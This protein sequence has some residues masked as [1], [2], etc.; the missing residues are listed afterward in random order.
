MMTKYDVARLLQWQRLEK[1]GGCAIASLLVWGGMVI[2]DSC[3][4]GGCAI[5]QTVTA[6]GT[7]G[8]TVT[9]TGP[10]TI[11]GGTTQ[12]ANLFHSFTEFSPSTATTEFSV[13]GTIER[14]FS[15]V[16]GS[17]VSNIDGILRVTGGINPDFFLINPNGIVFG[18]NAELDMNGSFIGSTASS[19]VF[20][21]NLEF[22]A[23]DTTVS[24][25][26]TINQPI[27]L[28]LGSNPGSIVTQSLTED[29]EI[30]DQTIG[31][32]GGEITIDQTKIEVDMGR[33]ELLAGANGTV[34]LS[35]DSLVI[36]ETQPILGEWRNITLKGSDAELEANGDGAGTIQVQGATVALTEASEIQADTFGT[37]SG[38]EIRIYAT[39][40]IRLSGPDPTDFGSF[41]LITT[42]VQNGANATGA[43]IILEA[44]NM[45]FNDGAFLEAKLEG[46]GQGGNITLNATGNIVFQGADEDGFSS[47]ISLEVDDTGVGQ[48]GS[49]FL[50]AQQL[51]MRE[52][53]VID[54]D[55]EGNGNGGDINITVDY[56][57]LSGVDPGDDAGSIT[58]QV[59]RRNPFTV[60]GGNINITA[61]DIVLKDGNSIESSTFSDGN[62]GNVSITAQRITVDSATPDEDGRISRIT[63]GSEISSSSSANL[64]PT[65]AGGTINLTVSDLRVINNGQ[66]FAGT[67]TEGNAGDL[68]ITGQTITIENGGLVSVNTTGSGNAG[69]LSINATTL[70][71]NESGQ[72]FA[73][74]EAAGNAGNLN[75]TGQTVTIENDGIVSVSSTGTGNAGNLSVNATNLYLN[76]GGQLQAESSAGSQ[77]NID[78]TASEILLLRRGS[79]ISTNATGSATGGNIKINAPVIAGYE[80]SDIV[81]NAV[82]GAGGN[83]NIT[84]Q[85]I[86]GLAFRDQLTS[87]NDITASSQFGVSGTIT[88]NDFSLDPSSGLVN[89][90][91]ALA[92]SSEQVDNTCAAAG[93]NEFI[94]TGR[95]GV[96]PNAEAQSGSD[97]PWSDLRDL[98]AFLNTPAPSPEV[99]PTTPNVIRE[100]TGFQRLANG[101]VVLLAESGAR[102]SQALHATCAIGS[103]A[104]K[105]G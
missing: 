66:I 90:A 80:N 60:Q 89:L 95:G 75:I 42:E 97:R 28:N 67:E 12:G 14:I 86:F 83:I 88:V 57:E 6:D 50:N 26:L 9:G 47:Q 15:R 7:V 10:F 69:N 41:P 23:N 65:G 29:F 27:G 78:L 11:T 32:I 104:M 30:S 99:L 53:A 37:I 16:T 68:N 33:I 92:D 3:A 46:T 54:V 72:V 103:G 94:A 40:S 35:K 17:N 63:S 22:S 101:Q 34:G 93:Q 45:L 8:T 98:S 49:L 58:T 71:L 43:N 55:T 73:G 48:G 82:L 21:H 13:G 81:A 85:G 70:S 39:E 77:G 24:P 87:E 62:A 56:L 44:P 76:Q 31:L 5:A 91:L 25:L 102:R 61:Q 74:T 100:A 1:W 79:R 84:T 51:F 105:S 64:N 38:G 20:P 36:V 52:G 59:D 19:I 4:I 18:P 96:P 2:G